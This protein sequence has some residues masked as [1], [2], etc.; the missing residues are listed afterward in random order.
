MHRGLAMRKLSGSL[1]VHLSNVWIV[2]KWK[3]VLPR[4]L[5]HMKHHLS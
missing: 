2:T 3:K 4:F 5:Y 1:S